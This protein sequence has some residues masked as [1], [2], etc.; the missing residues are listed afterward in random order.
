MALSARSILRGIFPATAFLAYVVSII[1]LHDAPKSAWQLE[2]QAA[3]PVAVSYVYYHAPFGSIDTGVWDAV[4]RNLRA[5]PSI[6]SFLGDIVQGDIHPGGIMATTIDGTA[7]GY[8]LFATASLLLFGFRTIS[9]VFGFAILLGTSVLVFLL[10]FRDGRALAIPIV[11][12]ALTVMLFTSH[13]TVQYWVDQAPIG[14]YRFFVI[15]GIVPTLHIILELF[16]SA[17]STTRQWTNSLL[18]VLQVILLVGVASARMTAA[19]FLCAV[20]FTAF[21]LIWRCRHDVSRRRLVIAKTA[22]LLTAA[23]AFYMGERLAVP[24]AYKGLGLASEPFWHRAFIGLGAHPDWP[25]GNLAA[26]LDCSPDVPNGLVP[27]ITDSDGHCAYNAAVKQGAA[28]GPV[29]GR[30]YEKLLRSAFFDIVYEY[31]WKVLE[32][33]LVYKPLL[34]LKT[35]SAATTLDISRQSAPIMIALAIQ[36]VLLIVMIAFTPPEVGRLRELLGAFGLVGVSSLMPQLVAWSTVATST[37][38][39]CYMYSALALLLVVVGRYMLLWWQA[40][41]E[42]EARA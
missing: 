15:A 11:F 22:I 17:N 16:D 26:T 14:G 13:A 20:A 35:L 38:L 33:Y 23:S 27:G 12:L 34:I 28:P 36:F 2:Q 24:D 10:R 3:I 7:L 19:Y 37:D 29:Y 4:L 6:D 41:G 18:L 5:G 8:P 30:Q 40:R 42:S 21:V 32:T 25:F 39:I 9:L 1:W 31:P